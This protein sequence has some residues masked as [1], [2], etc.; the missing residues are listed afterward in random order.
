MS[1]GREEAC[2]L[3]PADHGDRRQKPAILAVGAARRRTPASGAQDVSEGRHAHRDLRKDSR[4]QHTTSM[5]VMCDHFEPWLGIEGGEHGGRQ[6]IVVEPR[7]AQGGSP[8]GH[9]HSGSPKGTLLS[10]PGFWVIGDVAASRCCWRFSD[11]P[12][13][14]SLGW[15]LRL[16][17]HQPQQCTGRRLS[18]TRRLRC[19]PSGL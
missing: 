1:W 3:E 11:A 16:S 10:T 15:R 5:P 4:P 7:G 17:Y 18:Q 12:L 14:P 2:A 6:A 19:F 8:K 13:R 9:G